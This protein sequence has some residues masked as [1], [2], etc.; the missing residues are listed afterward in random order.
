M[1]RSWFGIDIAA[2]TFGGTLYFVT[3]GKLI[4]PLS[5]KNL[6]LVI[7]YSGIK[8]DRQNS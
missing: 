4:E 1:F 8:T 6:S 5:V 7:G 2:A 3:G